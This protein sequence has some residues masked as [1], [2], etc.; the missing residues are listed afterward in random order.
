[1]SSY[2]IQDGSFKAAKKLGVRIRPSLNPKKKID[3]LDWNGEFITSI[4]DVN[5]PDYHTYLAEGAPKPY[6]DIRRRLYLIRHAKDRA[7]L[8]S[9]GYYSSK[10]LWT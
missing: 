7:V 5:Y 9:R 1:M 6:A 2:Q 4:G 10:I 8:G 3:V